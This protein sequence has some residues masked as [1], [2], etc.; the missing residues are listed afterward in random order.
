M[1]RSIIRD[2]CDLDLLRSRGLD[3][4]LKYIEGDTIRN[5]EVSLPGDLEKKTDDYQTSQQ[6]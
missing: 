4:P 6:E 5:K 3:D 1:R 2:A